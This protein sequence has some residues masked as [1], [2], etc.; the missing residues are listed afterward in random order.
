[1]LETTN[2]LEAKTIKIQSSLTNI[3]QQCKGNTVEFYVAWRWMWLIYKKKD[4]EGLIFS[5]KR[6]EFKLNKPLQK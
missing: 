5:Q 1:M 6:F 2:S 4:Y 3:Q